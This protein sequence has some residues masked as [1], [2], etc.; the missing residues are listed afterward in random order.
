[1]APASNPRPWNVFGTR[2]L[3][4]Q[5]T[6][7]IA[8]DFVRYTQDETNLLQVEDLTEFEVP[9]ER[10]VRAGLFGTVNFDKPWSF[11]IVGAYRGFGQGFDREKGAAWALFDF[12]LTIPIP[13]L[14]RLTL[15]KTKEPFSMERLMGGGVQP[16]LE[17]AVG[18]DALTPTRN[19]G[20]QLQNSLLRVFLA[21]WKT[22][23][24][25]LCLAEP[26]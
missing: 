15:G 19:A 17:R 1:V 26:A 9:E 12:S 20:A 6:G 10:A 23:E 7:A 25:T 2:W 4:V 14:G 13:R 18:T 8:L 22:I 16:G 5:P 3:T 21:F 11:Y 24:R